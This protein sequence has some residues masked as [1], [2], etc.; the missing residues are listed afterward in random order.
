MLKYNETFEI[1]RNIKIWDSKTILKWDDFEI[2]VLR[3]EKEFK[4][5]DINKNFQI[6]LKLSNWREFRPNHLIVMIDLNL[7]IRSNPEQKEK[8]LDLFDNIFYKKDYWDFL[9][10]LQKVKFE[11]FLYDIEIISS[12]YLLFLIEQEY[13]YPDNKSKYNPKTLFLHWWIRQFILELKEI[14]N[15]VMSVCNRQPP[16]VWYTF[17]D[18]KNHRKYNEK[19]KDKWYLENIK[20]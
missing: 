5:Y 2:Y 17:E 6:F 15:L 19:R 4:N 13:N 11:H 3:P 16:K 20:Q 12:L 7:R 8:L 9:K 10:E 1:I 18:D 14:D